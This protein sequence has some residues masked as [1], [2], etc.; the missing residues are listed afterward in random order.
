MILVSI[1]KKIS[2][3]K[4]DGGPEIIYPKL[5][6]KGNLK[7]APCSRNDLFIAQKMHDKMTV[8]W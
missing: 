5:F 6:L 4:K 3:M 2:W 7:V 1:W 8:Q